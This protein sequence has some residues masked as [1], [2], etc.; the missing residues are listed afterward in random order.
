MGVQAKHSS[1]M[2]T[3]HAF[4]LEQLF[5]SKTRARLLGVF[6]NN[7]DKRFF[8]RELTRKIDAQ[9]NSVRRE[10]QNLVELGLVKESGQ[11]QNGKKTSENKKF[12]QA[13]ADSLLY[14]DLR[15]LLQKVQVLL[16]KNLVSE[17][18]Q[19]GKLLYVAL[20]GKFVQE[21]DVP[22]DLIVVG[23]MD[24]KD[25]QGIVRR[26]EQELGEEVNYTFMPKDEYMYRKQITDKF[27]SSILDANKIV[28]IDRLADAL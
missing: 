18:D 7:A 20:T 12:F 10:I 9:L 11:D 8:V 6:L 26:F 5:G 14:H 1:T 28:M 21:P 2:G 23:T 27:L 15:A 25:L 22:V 4:R 3:Q 16:K 13:N 17:I 19:K 24:Q